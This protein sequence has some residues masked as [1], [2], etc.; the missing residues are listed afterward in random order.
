M[1]LIDF[2]FE[3]KYIF[4]LL[5][6]FTTIGINSNNNII[7]YFIT[8]VLNWIICFIL[9]YLLEKESKS[10]KEEE[11][12]KSK[13]IGFTIEEKKIYNYE[14]TVY[15]KIQV[16]ILYFFYQM[17]KIYFFNVK[18]H[19]VYDSFRNLTLI[20]LILSNNFFFSKEKMYMHHFVSITGLIIL[21]FFSGDF[22]ICST[23]DIRGSILYFGLTGFCVT[24]V[25]Y[26]MQNKF[27]SPYLA[28]SVSN[29]FL[30]LKV[31]Y[32][33]MTEEDKSRF[34]VFNIDFHFFYFLISGTLN[35]IFKHLI[36]YYFS[37]F[38]YL[39]VFFIEFIYSK[40]ILKESFSNFDLFLSLFFVLIYVEIIILN[41]WKLGEFTKKN[42]RKRGDKINQKLMK[43]LQLLEKK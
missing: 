18:R 9:S 12:M 25:K 21:M 40:E 10:E 43:A 7:L 6:A 26:L 22:L 3:T 16:F 11:K 38:H 36:L 20:F 29:F 5:N 39:I 17:I 37:P 1:S 30:F 4:I 24:Y 14:S 2:S 33:V 28:A 19:L 23:K 27:L 13:S 32:I 42:V 15:T 8:T 35:T 31:F 41:F 34:F